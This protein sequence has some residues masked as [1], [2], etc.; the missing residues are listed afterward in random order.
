M[1]ALTSVLCA[2]KQVF[3]REGVPFTG[4]GALLTLGGGRAG[5]PPWTWALDTQ[6]ITTVSSDRP[7]QEELSYGIAYADLDETRGIWCG[8]IAKVKEVSMRGPC[9]AASWVC[10]QFFVCTEGHHRQCCGL[11]LML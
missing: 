2:A 8:Q 1:A 5:R 10:Y 9:F 11:H 7:P 6:R 3:A 4:P